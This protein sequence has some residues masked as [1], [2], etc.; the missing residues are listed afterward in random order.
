MSIKKSNIIINIY[1]SILYKY[2]LFFI[3][4]AII[5]IQGCASQAPAPVIRLDQSGNSNGTSNVLQRD[6]SQNGEN[7]LSEDTNGD[8]IIVSA[9]DDLEPD[10]IEAIELQPEESDNASN[11][12]S[13]QSE[14]DFEYLVQPKDTFYSLSRKFGVPVSSLMEYNSITSTSGLIAGQTIKIPKN[15]DE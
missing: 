10:I 1:I 2:R 14:Q 6:S 5:I 8:E 12:D 11:A 7:R 4:T 13:N 15:S 3:A 9:Y